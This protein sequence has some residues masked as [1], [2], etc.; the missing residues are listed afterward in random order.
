MSLVIIIISVILI[1]TLF[2]DRISAWF[3]SMLL[4]KMEDA[5]RRRMGMPTR[6]E[7]KKREKQ[8]RS[9]GNRG[10]TSYNSSYASSARRGEYSHI[11]IAII[12]REYA[13]DVEYVEYKSF[14]STEDSTSTGSVSFKIENQVSDAVYQEFKQ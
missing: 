12:L 4:G 13:E 7:Q 14:T 9:A 11:S 5:V 3:R 10:Y 2:G 6:K 1:W 8:S